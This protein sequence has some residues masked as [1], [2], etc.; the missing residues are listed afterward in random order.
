MRLWSCLNWTAQNIFPFSLK[1]NNKNNHGIY[2]L[3]ASSKPESKS[4]SE[5][6]K[7]D[8]NDISI[9][10]TCQFW[11]VHRW[12]P[13]SRKLSLTICQA[14]STIPSLVLATTWRGSLSAASS[15]SW[16]VKEGE[17]EGEGGTD[18]T[19]DEDSRASGEES[20]RLNER[21]PVRTLMTAFLAQLVLLWIIGAFC[22][23]CLCGLSLGKE[24]EVQLLQFKI[25][26]LIFSSN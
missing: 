1:S 4:K 5:L 8:V 22:S 3:L 2:Y 18:C 17:G 7:F 25:K 23:E 11:G 12:R 6:K 16:Q 20:K 19:E 10:S 9:T 26:L 21:A 14:S 13:V 24:D 15:P